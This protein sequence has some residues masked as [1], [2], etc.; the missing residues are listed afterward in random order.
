MKDQPEP[1]AA[2]RAKVSVLFTE[3]AGVLARRLDAATPGTSANDAIALALQEEFGLEKAEAV[4][5]HLAD[6]AADAAFLVALQLFPERFTTAEVAAG[7]EAFLC[8]VPKHV[9]AAA[10]LHGRFPVEGMFG[11]RPEGSAGFVWL[12]HGAGG[13]FASGVFTT[14]ERAEVWIALHGLSGVLTRYA[15]DAGAYEQAVADRSFRPSQ[16]QHY[17]A[18]FI[19]RFADGSVHQHYE[20]GSRA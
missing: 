15:V 1:D 18:E 16:P 2:C 6:W 5:Y 17:T 4:G 3:L 9:L 13:R 11:V 7:V 19:Q 20:A 8:H 12:F 14:Q 10:A